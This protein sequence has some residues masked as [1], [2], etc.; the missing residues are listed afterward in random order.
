MQL[1]KDNKILIVKKLK[2]NEAYV[3]NERN[4][5]KRV[6]LNNEV[7]K[8]KF[9]GIIAQLNIIGV[10]KVQYE[11]V[12]YRE[13]MMPE[14]IY[15]LNEK[16][17][18]IRD[19]ILNH[20][21]YA[22]YDGL[23]KDKLFKGNCIITDTSR[24]VLLRKYCKINGWKFNN[25][26]TTEGYPFVILIE[27]IYKISYKLRKGKIVTWIDRKNFIRCVKGE[28]IK[29]NQ[30]TQD[31]SAI[32]SRFNEIIKELNI[33]IEIRFSRSKI[34]KNMLFEKDRGAY[35]MVECDN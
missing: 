26:Q 4:E 5:Y 1:R 13:E 30:Y 12:E 32:K 22:A 28:K 31:C 2:G 3:L 17:I 8:E 7:K 21:A 15:S 34:E 18:H 23:K 25:V 35:L 14:E 24:S 9:R 27:N 33:E 20:A 10:L 11:E 16:E 6:E 29:S 19:C